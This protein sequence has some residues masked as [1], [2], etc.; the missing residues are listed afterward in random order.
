MI[1]ATYFSRWK[2]VKHDNT[3]TWL[4]FWNDPINPKR[5][6]YVSLSASSSQKGQRDK[7]KYEKARNLKVHFEGSLLLVYQ[8]FLS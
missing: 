2:E 8:I 1:D 3:V 7:E 6:K 5:F 4:A